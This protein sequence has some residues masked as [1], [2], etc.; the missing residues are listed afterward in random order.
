MLVTIL[1]SHTGGSIA[2]V[3]WPRRDVG[4]ES[5][6]QQGCRVMLVIALLSLADDSAAMSCW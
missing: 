2:E 5:C 4:A 6:W 3:T 1:P